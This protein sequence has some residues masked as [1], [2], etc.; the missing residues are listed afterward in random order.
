MGQ[1]HHT[2]NKDTHNTLTVAY[3]FLMQLPVMTKAS[4]NTWK[5]KL[6][7]MDIKLRKKEAF[8]AIRELLTNK[9]IHNFKQVTN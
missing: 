2:H 6:T 5:H 4:Y 7:K 3:L 9:K 1:K 8:L